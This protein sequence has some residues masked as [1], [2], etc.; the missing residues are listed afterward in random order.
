MIIQNCHPEDPPI[1]GL[2]ELYH[3]ID[4]KTF[5]VNSPCILTTGNMLIRG[6]VY[7]LHD[8]F[9]SGAKVR[10]IRLLWVYLVGFSFYII[11]VDVENG[12]LVRRAQ[13]LDKDELPCRFL[14]AE[15]FFFIDMA[16]KMGIGTID[17]E[18]QN[19]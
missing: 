17:D 6:E 15:R 13:R 1:N 5:F 16:N 14:L 12:E 3:R 18:N 2:Y 19:K 8:V 4:D 7:E 9:N 11:G 10:Y